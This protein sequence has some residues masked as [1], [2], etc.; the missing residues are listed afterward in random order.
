MDLDELKKLS[1][2]FTNIA[3]PIAAIIIALIARDATI[4]AASKRRKRR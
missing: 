1:D 2:I 3:Q 4:K